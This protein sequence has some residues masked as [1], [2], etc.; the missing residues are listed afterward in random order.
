MEIE[1]DFEKVQ[2]SKQETEVFTSNGNAPAVELVRDT[3]HKVCVDSIEDEAWK[4]LR[5]SMVYYCASPI[6][7]IAVKDPTRPLSVTLYLL[8]SFLIERRV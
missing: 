8:Y 7:R 5:E 1:H 2:E 4:L 6:G 3:L